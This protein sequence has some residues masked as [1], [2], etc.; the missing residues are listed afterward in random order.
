MPVPQDSDSDSPFA[1]EG[2]AGAQVDPRSERA[3]AIVDFRLREIQ[4]ILAFDVARTHVIADGAAHNRSTRIQNE[5][6]LRLRNTPAGVAPN[7]DRLAGSDDFLRQSLEKNLRPLRR[8]NAVVRGGAEIGFLHPG[9]L[10]AQVS[11]PRGPHFLSF[12]R[13]AKP[14]RGQWNARQIPPGDLVQLRNRIIAFQQRMELSDSRRRQIQQRIL[15]R[16]QPDA[17][18]IVLVFEAADFHEKPRR[19]LNRA[20]AR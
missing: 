14:D 2:F 8:I 16:Y 7:A 18:F 3:G 6:E 12:N 20:S 11:D 9:R 15:I 1:R 5:R 17:D 4:E 13:R 19:F 10:A